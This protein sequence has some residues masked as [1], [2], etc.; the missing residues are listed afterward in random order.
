MK[1]IAHRGASGSAPENTLSAF[2]LAL[3]MGSKAFEFDVHRTKD[4]K[5]VVRHDYELERASGAPVRVAAADYD[6]LKKINVGNKFGFPSER[7]PLL[8]EVLGL[9]HPKAE[10]INFE[11]KND[12]NIYPGIEAD[13]LAFVRARPGLMKKALFSS[14]DYGTLERLRALDKNAAL[15]YLGHRLRSILLLPAIM[16]A[17]AVGAVNFHLTLRLAF[18]LNIA[19]IRKAGLKVCVYTVNKKADALRLQR[20]GVDGIFSDFPDIL[21][22]E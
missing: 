11:V 14:F 1:I 6:E 4:G 15:G 22:R 16:R 17:R 18:G 20:L 3:K 13:L 7:V 8:E 9:L 19:L 12:G 5:L 21:T 10:W 2:E